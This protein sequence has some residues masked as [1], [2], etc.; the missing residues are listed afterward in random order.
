MH[1]RQSATATAFALALGAVVSAAVADDHSPA[2]QQGGQ[3][4]VQVHL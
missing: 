4:P 1:M 3:I 2:F